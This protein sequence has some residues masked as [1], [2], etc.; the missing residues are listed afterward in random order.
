[1][2]KTVSEMM[3]HMNLIAQSMGDWCPPDKAYTLSAMVLALRPRTIVE[4]GV[5]EGGSFIPLALAA[6]AI[7]ACRAIAIDPWDAAASAENQNE[8]NGAWWAK[9]PHDAAFEKFMGRVHQYGL[10]EIVDVVRARSDD[11][12][13]PDRI[14]ILHIDGNHADQAVKDVW[15]FAP[16]VP[17]G[18]I[19]IL[20]DI[21]W[22]GGHVRRAAE[23]LVRLGFEWRYELGTG[24][25]YL[26]VRS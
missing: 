24:A 17:V 21:D 1:M 20:D 15:R 4:I 7:G 18:G 16:F 11:A 8:V 26:R 3:T 12:P 23:E 25:A 14:D 13:I 9:A 22:E 10:A 6:R 2:I 19:V 5:W